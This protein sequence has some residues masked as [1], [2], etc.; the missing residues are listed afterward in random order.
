MALVRRH[1]PLLIIILLYSHHLFVWSSGDNVKRN[2]TLVTIGEIWE[3]Q[4]RETKAQNMLPP[5]EIARGMLSQEMLAKIM[6]TAVFIAHVYVWRWRGEWYE[7]EFW[8]Q[9]RPFLVQPSEEK[10]PCCN[11][12]FF[13]T[14]LKLPQCIPHCL[15][16]GEVLLTLKT[17]QKDRKLLSSLTQKTWAGSNRFDETARESNLRVPVRAYE[18]FRPNESRARVWLTSNSHPCLAWC[19]I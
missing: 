13:V 2:F 4:K 12:T 16:I 1:F 7:F 11:S 15:L 8:R 18:S 6:L 5:W 17:G 3:I 10:T 9:L 19:N 14:L